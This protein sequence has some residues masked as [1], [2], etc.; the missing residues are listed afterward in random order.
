MSGMGK[1][2]DIQLEHEILVARTRL[3]TLYAEKRARK[4]ASIV[5]RAVSVARTRERNLEIRRLRRY[6][7][8]TYQQL[9]VRFNL[10]RDTVR[11]IVLT[12][13]YEDRMARSHEEWRIARETAA[14]LGAST[15]EV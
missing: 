14:T 8:L 9:S 4:T 13:D 15:G 10:S 2:S 12:L 11:H 6:Q 5:P 1:L 7:K 3:Y